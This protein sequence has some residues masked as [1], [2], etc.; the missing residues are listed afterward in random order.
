MSDGFVSKALSSHSLAATGSLSAKDSL[1]IPRCASDSSGLSNKASSYA[2]LA[3]SIFLSP[4]LAWPRMAVNSDK[5]VSLADLK[6]KV[7]GTATDKKLVGN[8]QA[9]GSDVSNTEYNLSARISA[10]LSEL[11]I[12]E[13]KG[14]IKSPQINDDIDIQKGNMDI[15]KQT[16]A[17]GNIEFKFGDRPVQMSFS[18]ASLDEIRSGG[19]RL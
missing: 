9:Q 18:G 12:D 11:S 8:I 14:H 5:A 4:K 2:P 17:A 6:G 16:S 3:V 13:L 7:T 1:A 19:R 10:N 15:G